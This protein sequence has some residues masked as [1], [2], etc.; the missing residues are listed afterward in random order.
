[1]IE[2]AKK[3]KIKYMFLEVRPSNE[4]AIFLYK[5]QGLYL[6][7]FDRN[8]TPIITKMQF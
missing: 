3:R 1:M 2:T 8:I 5:K 6:A 7:E 4:R